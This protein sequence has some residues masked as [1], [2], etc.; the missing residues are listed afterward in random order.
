[1]KRIP[2]GGGL[3]GGSADAG[4]VLRAM[5]A[6]ADEPLDSVMPLA[7]HLGADVPFLAS[8]APYAL[9]WGRG[10]RMVALEPPPSRELL[11]VL[12]GFG[13]NTAQAYDWVDAARGP[14]AAAVLH[15]PR[16]FSTWRDLRA[17]A[18]NDFDAV[19]RA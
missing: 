14:N 7:V 1:E 19:V 6:I 8:E 10:E 4:G 5:N 13:V 12:P 18:I 16:E 9:A 15:E 3:G 11:L 2:I 17:A